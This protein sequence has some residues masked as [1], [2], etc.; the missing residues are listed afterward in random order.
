M[1]IYNG[2]S[3]TNVLYLAKSMFWNVHLAKYKI[4]VSGIEFNLLGFNSPMLA[5]KK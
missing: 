4:D 3:Q 5:S 1:F 2:F